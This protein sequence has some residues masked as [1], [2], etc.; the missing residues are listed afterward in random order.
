M[1]SHAL[2]VTNVKENEV[3]FKD[4]Y[5]GSSYTMAWEEFEKLSPKSI[6]SVDLTEA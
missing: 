5:N 1:G 6:Y 4:P 3:T 2:A